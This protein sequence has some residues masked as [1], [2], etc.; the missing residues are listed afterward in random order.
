M[1][2]MKPLTQAEQISKAV[3]VRMKDARVE[4][5]QIAQ[6]LRAASKG[7]AAAGRRA[8]LI[9]KMTGLSPQG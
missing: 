1:N 3:Q 2:T 6:T 9:A 4:V 5:A 7:S 8:V